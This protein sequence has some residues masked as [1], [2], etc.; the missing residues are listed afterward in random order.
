M[1][2]NQHVVKT[3]RG[4]AVRGEGNSRATQKFDKQSEAVVYARTVAMNANGEL[5]IHGCDGRIRERNSYAA[6]P[7][8][9]RK[10]AGNYGNKKNK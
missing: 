8:P 2:K 4:W 3:D 6:D 1:A 10:N 5:I 9:P 7:C